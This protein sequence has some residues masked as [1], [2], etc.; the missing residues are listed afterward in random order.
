MML[1]EFNSYRMAPLL[2]THFVA[3]VVPLFALLATV[4]TLH[5]DIAET[6]LN[7][8]PVSA[9]DRINTTVIVPESPL[10]LTLNSFSLMVV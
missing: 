5:I 8:E 9:D 10:A 2:A 3:T 7:V 1:G 4:S 6:G